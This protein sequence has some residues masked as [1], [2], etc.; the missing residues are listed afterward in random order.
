[1]DIYTLFIFGFIGGCA[2]EI[3][4]IQKMLK[5]G[6]DIEIPHP[7][8]YIIISIFMAILGGILAIGFESPNIIGAI[9]IGASTPLIINTF[10]KYAPI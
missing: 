3:V 1:M 10:T 8:T 9:W 5:L 4:R 7:I 2:P 6:E